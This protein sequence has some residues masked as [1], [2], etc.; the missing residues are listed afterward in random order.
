GTEAG[1]ELLAEAAQIGYDIKVIG[2]DMSWGEA[3]LR[4]RDAGIL[5]GLMGVAIGGP[6]A[7]LGDNNMSNANSRIHEAKKALQSV[8]N[9]ETDP[10]GKGTKVSREE[11][12]KVVKEYADAVNAK[13]KLVEE[14]KEAEVEKKKAKTEKKETKRKAKRT[15]KEVTQEKKQAK[16]AASDQ[17]VD[18]L[19]PEVIEEADLIESA[20]AR[21]EISQKAAQGL[22]DK[23]LAKITKQGVLV[24]L[25]AGNRRL[26]A[27]RK[28]QGDVKL[29]VKPA[30]PAVVEAPA[31]LKEFS[32]RERALEKERKAIFKDLD[33]RV[34]D[35]E[36]TN[37]QELASPEMARANEISEELKDIAQE[38]KV[39]AK[40]RKAKQG[41]KGAKASRAAKTTKK[42]VKPI[43][44]PI[45]KKDT[46]AS[47][48]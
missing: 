31:E 23:G 22:V 33:Q 27:V 19:T 17:A 11:I 1:Q 9:R 24:V 47:R 36:L 34:A 8:A 46:V 16:A 10:A 29:E 3:V 20:V 35:G 6:V 38:R 37:E 2:D 30:L 48:K 43:V 42:I 18:K 15:P 4:L 39:A 45:V 32:K 40:N 25:P 41:A 5:G 21:E 26:K 14:R 28:A 44:K 13:R 7:I 12:D